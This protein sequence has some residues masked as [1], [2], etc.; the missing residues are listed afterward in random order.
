MDNK[1][2]RTLFVG[3]TIIAIII[4]LLLLRSCSPSKVEPQ[5]VEKSQKVV[6]EEKEVESKE[7]KE[8]IQLLNLYDL[9]ARA[10]FCSPQWN[11]DAKNVVKELQTLAID[12]QESDSDAAELIEQIASDL[13]NL[14]NKNSLENINSLEATVIEFENLSG[15]R[16][17]E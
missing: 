7:K 3:C 9:L 14:A 11:K 8:V 12:K 6:V 4:F 2:K 1:F 13:S 16:S 5:I 17:N 15:G 10:D